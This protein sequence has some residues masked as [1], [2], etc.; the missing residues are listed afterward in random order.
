MQTAVTDACLKPP[1]VQPEPTFPD[2]SAQGL[3]CHCDV[4]ASQER[5]MAS[6]RSPS[7]ESS[8]TLPDPSFSF[9]KKSP[10]PKVIRSA[11]PYSRA[12]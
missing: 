11:S 8:S 7:D 2:S 3:L 6:R 1:R 10:A 4:K 12:E 5:Y 9:R